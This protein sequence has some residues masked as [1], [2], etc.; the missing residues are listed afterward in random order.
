MSETKNKD[1]M[2]EP[3]DKNKHKNNNEFTEII[4]QNLLAGTEEINENDFNSESSNYNIDTDIDNSSKS[5]LN[6]G[7]VPDNNLNDNYDENITLEGYSN[8]SS[9]KENIIQINVSNTPNKIR[10]HKYT[11][12]KIEEY[13]N[14][15]YFEKNHKYSSSLDIIATYLRGQKLIYMESKSYCEYNLNML[16]LPSIM[17]STL[18]TIL[19]GILSGIICNY[20]SFP[21]VI[22]F[23]LMNGLIS[24]LLAIVNYLKLDAAAEAHKISAHQYDKLQTNIE[25]LSGK[26]LLFGNND[27]NNDLQSAHDIDVIMGEKLTEIEKK[28][29]EIKETNQF[30]VPK[31]VRTRY[32]IMYNTNIFLIIKKIDDVKKRKINNLKEIKNRTNYLIAVME[33]KKQKNK[34]TTVRNLQYKIKELYEKKN[35]HIKEILYLK[36]AFSIIDEMFVKEMEN[37][38]IIKKNRFLLWLGFSS[39]KKNLVDPRELNH[40]IKNIM[41]P[42]GSTSKLNTNTNMTDKILSEHHNKKEDILDKIEKGLSTHNNTPLKSLP[43]NS[44]NVFNYW[45][46]NEPHKNMVEETRDL[47]HNSDSS[48][49]E[50]DSNMCRHNSLF[51]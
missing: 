46:K 3:V 50:M 24:F 23:A 4:L 27:K 15:N 41:D 6:F 51:S 47:R 28:I 10:F 1:E 49:S 48:I 18:A 43:I 35:D 36:S 20:E 21:L 8:I 22:L 33:A 26:T 16:M 5:S 40:F 11:Y 14:D 34:M 9:N 42:Y 32:S 12:K 29:S 44:I 17:L 31:L 25:F 2:N 7:I 38:E 37:A 13:I 30:I 39:I 45:K 19:S